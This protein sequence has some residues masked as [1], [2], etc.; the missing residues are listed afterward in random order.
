MGRFECPPGIKLKVTGANWPKEG[1]PGL[2]LSALCWP[3]PQSRRPPLQLLRQHKAALNRSNPPASPPG[4]AEAIKGHAM[5]CW[6]RA[7]AGP[8]A[9]S[10]RINCWMTAWPPE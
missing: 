3:S 5:G 10:V 7:E 6:G 9:R 4:E 1:R 8:W 2:P